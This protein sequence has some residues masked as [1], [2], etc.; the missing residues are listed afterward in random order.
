MAREDA[1]GGVAA[2]ESSKARLGTVEGEERH[3]GWNGTMVV[4]RRRI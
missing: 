1:G 3:T 2:R 4:E